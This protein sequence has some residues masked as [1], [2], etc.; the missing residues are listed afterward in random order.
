MSSPPAHRPAWSAQFQPE[1][2]VEL[3]RVLGLD[4][5]SANWAYGDRL[6]A[7]VK[8]AVIDSGVEAE[9]PAVGGRVTFVSVVEGSDGG[10]PVIE[11]ARHPDDFGH[12]TACAAIIR[13]A[14]PDCEIFSIKVLGGTL[15]G[16]GEV[17]TAG[18]KWAI[19]NGMQVCSL[20]L[21]TTNREFFP[22]LHTLA[23][24][25][26]F[27]NI[28]LVAAANNMPIPSFPSMYSSVISVASHDI[29]DPELL[30][31]NPKPPVEFGA[32]GLGV[33][34]AW[35]GGTYMTVNGNSF[36]APHVT[37]LVA[38]ILGAHPELTVFQ[39]K[40]VLH[41]LSS[42]VGSPPAPPG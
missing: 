26:Y 8:V 5:F 18:L 22:T 35:K 1:S 14:A 41:A 40:A 36:A 23:D 31:Y 21:G 38:R 27:R 15:G 25:A 4:E 11:M 10:P 32:H 37:G 9:H 17:F 2:L 6:G 20:S 16:H 24:V 33:R 19:D 28:P 3:P 34:A 30:Y 7:G 29:P 13:A 12:G 42:N 39:V